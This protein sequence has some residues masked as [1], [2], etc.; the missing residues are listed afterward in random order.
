VIVNHGSRMYT[1][2]AHLGDV[3]VGEGDFVNE[4]QVIASVGETGSLQGPMLYFELRDG[5]RPVNP[6]TWLG[7]K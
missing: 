4:G 1:I 7:K 6:V 2:Y 5:S 3:F